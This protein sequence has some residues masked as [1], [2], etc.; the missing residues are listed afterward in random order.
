[1]Q[2]RMRLTDI[3]VDNC[4]S[5]VQLSSQVSTFSIA[6]LEKLDLLEMSLVHKVKPRSFSGPGTRSSPPQSST[7][8]VLLA[9]T[10][11]PIFKGDILEYPEFRRKWKALV[12]PANLPAEAEFDKL[13]ESVPKLAKDQL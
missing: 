9:K 12:Q 6:Q 5:K 8:K 2:L 1:M 3:G 11:P 13:R 10:K 4:Y 7:D